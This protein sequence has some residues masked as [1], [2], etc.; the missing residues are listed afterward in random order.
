[1]EFWRSG[2]VRMNSE[3]PDCG[4]KIIYR[5]I[6]KEKAPVT[7]QC[8]SALNHDCKY[9][10]QKGDDFVVCEKALAEY[11]R[12]GCRNGGHFFASW[13]SIYRITPRIS[14]QL[15]VCCQRL[16]CDNSQII[17]GG[18][19]IKVC[20]AQFREE[21]MRVTLEQ[22]LQAIRFNENPEDVFIIED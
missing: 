19:P 7:L 1:M 8:C 2:Q 13:V 15:P 10:G 22:F 6:H 4:K 3:L 16:P 5:T 12:D 21:S 14:A 9:S 17:E 18:E 20:L 11:N